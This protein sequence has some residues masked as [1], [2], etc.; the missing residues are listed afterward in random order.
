MISLTAYHGIM[1]ARAKQMIA[2]ARPLSDRQLRLWGE[3]PGIALALI[4]VLVVVK[5]F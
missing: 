1:V 3:Y 2:G 4:V 5:P